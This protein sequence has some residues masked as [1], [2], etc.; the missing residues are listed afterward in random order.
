MALAKFPVLNSSLRAD[1]EALLQHAA[2]NIGVA[3]ATPSGLVV[4]PASSF[5][6][7]ETFSWRFA[8]VRNMQSACFKGAQSG[9]GTCQ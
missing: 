1:G 9:T 7:N 8:R 2:H 4:R 6:F 3:M 5:A